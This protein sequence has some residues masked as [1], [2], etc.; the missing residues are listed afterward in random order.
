MTSPPASPARPSA[1]SGQ[2]RLRGVRPEPWRRRGQRR[3]L[4]HLR[5]EAPV[6]RHSGPRAAEANL[7]VRLADA[8]FAGD[9]EA[10]RDI[11]VTLA[12]L[13]AARGRDLGTATALAQRAL[14]IAGDGTGGLHV[15]FD[16]DVC[17]PAIAPGV[18][19]PVKGS[20]AVTVQLPEER[21]GELM[22][23]RAFEG[24]SYGLVMRLERPVYV[25]DSARNPD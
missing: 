18:G 1:E 13:L 24:V 4:R 5:A 7:E 11:T 15:S 14:E 2:L 3:Q 19:T 6:P 16:L 17:D 12:R 21:A 8:R 25:M 10:E 23:F 9:L 20:N 22:V